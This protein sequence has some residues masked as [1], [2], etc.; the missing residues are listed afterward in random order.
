MGAASSNYD[1]SPRMVATMAN[2][3]WY[4]DH[5]NKVDQQAERYTKRMVERA[6]KTALKQTKF[7]QTAK[8]M[9]KD[10]EENFAQSSEAT[11]KRELRHQF[12]TWKSSYEKS[13]KGAN[14]ADPEE[15]RSL[16]L[17][18]SGHMDSSPRT[19]SAIRQLE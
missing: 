11:K 7:K 17:M 4:G 13:K 14:R 18:E 2:L 12:S 1:V 6:Q 9:S 19:L 3:P 5:R 16:F 15:L 10:R 8:Q